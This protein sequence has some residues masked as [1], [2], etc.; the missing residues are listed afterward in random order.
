MPPQ[1]STSL[2]AGPSVSRATSDQLND[3]VDA[4][5]AAGF[6]PEDIRREKVKK[7]VSRGAM[8]LL[9]LLGI[10]AVIFLVRQK[11]NGLPTGEYELVECQEGEDFFKYYTFFDGPDSLGSAGYNIYVSKERAHELG[12]AN[13]THDPETGKDRIFMQSAKT[14]KGHPRESIRLEGNRRFNH[15]L[16][17]LDLNHMPAGCGVWPAFWLTDEEN[18]PDNGEIDV[19]EGINRQHMVKTALHTSDQCSMYAHVPR[20]AWSGEWDTATGLPD[21][22]TGK[23][24]FKNRVEADNCHVMAAHQWA[25]QG[26]VAVDQRN[27]TLGAPL[28]AAGGGVYA[29][30]WDPA[31]GYI[32]SWAFPRSDG[33]PDNLQEALDT[34]SQPNKEDRVMPNTTDWGL[35]YAYFAIGEA[36][37]CSADHFKDMRVVINLAFCGTVAG[38]RFS[39]DCPEFAE[40]PTFN[41]KDAGDPWKTCEAYIESNPKALEQAY[42]DINGAYVYER[43]FD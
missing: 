7:T 33:L 12:I 3:E 6:S 30:E 37:G 42:W 36:T 25:N 24:S 2:L 4:L 38:N 28:N 15:G 31:N 23:P 11:E 17:L 20:W 14:Q 34:A 26:C 5:L 39:R 41:E 13:V 27:N 35:P 32:R 10:G 40:F 19:I 43:T 9:L 1:E 29:L 21:T 18:W 16:F 8:I 22:F